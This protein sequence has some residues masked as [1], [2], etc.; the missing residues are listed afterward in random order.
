MDIMLPNLHEQPAP[1]PWLVLH[2]QI[3][4]PELI[5]E[6]AANKPDATADEIAQELAQRNIHVPGM[7]VALWLQRLRGHTEFT[8]D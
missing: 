2:D 4:L 8:K 1:A 5:R 7:A 3:D 6:R